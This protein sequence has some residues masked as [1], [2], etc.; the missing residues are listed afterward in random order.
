MASLPP[1]LGAVLHV[2]AQLLL[3]P[4]STAGYGL[5]VAPL[6]AYSRRT[7]VSS[8]LLAS[9]YTR[10]IQH[11][12]RTRDDVPCARIMAVLPNV[13]QLGMDLVT[14]GTRTVRAVTGYVPRI[15]CTLPRRRPWR[16]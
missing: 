15:Y 4:V 14:V 8:T 9:F 2:E 7:G 1:L 11:E 12:L 6:L 5:T 10:W 16:S 3:L 13:S